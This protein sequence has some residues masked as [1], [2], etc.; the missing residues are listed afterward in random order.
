MEWSDLGGYAV[1][2]NVGYGTYAA[3][4]ACIGNPVGAVSG[5]NNVPGQSGPSVTFLGDPS[6]PDSVVI[7]V[8]NTNCFQATNGAQIQVNGFKVL[9]TGT[10]GLYAQQGVGLYAF[11]GGGIQF[12][13]I[14]FGACSQSHI[15]CT[16]SSIIELFE[17]V[18]HLRICDHSY[19]RQRRRLRYLRRFN[20]DANWKSG[21]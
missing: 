19:K 17:P 14:D 5:I 18:H 9:A 3:G 15:V 12:N 20:C 1:T 8:A 16:A 10:G 21:I 7:N 11:A 6:S 2:I 13:N 4:V